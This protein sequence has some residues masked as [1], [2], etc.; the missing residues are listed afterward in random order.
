MIFKRQFHSVLLIVSLTVSYTWGQEP[1]IKGTVPLISPSKGQIPND[2]GSDGQSKLTIEKSAELGP[3][4]AL[5]VVFAPGDSFGDR[6]A[7]V[8]NWKPYARLRFDVMNPASDTVSL[9]FNLNHKR[10]YNYQT[11]TVYPI[12]LKPGRN[13]VNIDLVSLVNVNGTS[14][15]LAN[16]IKWYFNCEDGKTPTLFFSDILLESDETAEPDSAAGTRRAVT[17]GRFRVQGKIGDAKVDLTVEPIDGPPVAAAKRVT[18]AGDSA[19]VARIHAAKMPKIDKVVPFDTPDA[20][21]ILSAMEIYPPDNPWNLIVSDWP[22]HPSSKAFVASIG[23][24]K[25]LRANRD[26]CFV[27]VP[28]NQPRVDVKLVGYPG[29]SDRGPF[30]V[31]DSLPIEGWPEWPAKDGKKL[32]LAE[33]QRRPPEYDGDRHA[34][35]V[36]PMAGKLYEFFVMGKTANGWAAD[37]SSVFDLKSNRLRPDGWTSADLPRSHPV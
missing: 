24:A 8:K 11:R 13:A 32:T 9:E 18:V 3:N 5:K 17:G 34:I 12:K 27:I 26:M 4:N 35:I 37:Q 23:E 7:R 14:P 1:A 6:S 29:E 22:L 30:P 16:V 31:P 10:T 36:D 33:V 15:D 20:D 2:T 28:P 21:A 25:V 19:R